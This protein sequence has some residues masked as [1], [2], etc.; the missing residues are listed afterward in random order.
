MA[1][2]NPT[3]PHLTDLDRRSTYGVRRTAYIFAPLYLSSRSTPSPLIQGKEGHLCAAVNHG[4]TL[5]FRGDR[6]MSGVKLT[7]GEVFPST[8]GD[9][10]ARKKMGCQ[11]ALPTGL[12][13]RRTGAGIGS[14]RGPGG[15]CSV[16][17]RIV[18][19]RSGAFHVGRHDRK[20]KQLGPV[21][22]VVGNG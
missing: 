22:G 4:R 15:S 21:K 18:L 7:G 10:T 6:R 8:E 17:S 20:R 1:F 12:H 14:G 16:G 13:P 19:W 3:L 5:L 9:S 2:Q 11:P